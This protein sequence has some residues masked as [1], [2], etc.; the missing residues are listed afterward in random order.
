MS[1]LQPQPMR[2]DALLLVHCLAVAN[3]GPS[4]FSRLQHAVGEELARLLVFALS[5]GQGRRGSS[6]P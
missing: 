2:G 3:D 6:S 5:G 1:V 4:A